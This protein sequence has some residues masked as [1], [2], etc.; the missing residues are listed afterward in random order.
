MP[1][2]VL[3]RRR[4]TVD[5]PNGRRSLRES[6]RVAVGVSAPQQGTQQIVVRTYSY[7][8]VV[9]RPPYVELL[10]RLYIDS[11][12]YLI[13]HPDL[14]TFSILSRFTPYSLHGH[15]S[16]EGSVDKRELHSQASPGKGGTARFFRTLSEV[17]GK[18]TQCS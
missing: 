9:R 14:V 10:Y 13:G 4:S 15:G 6:V 2:V 3:L 8:L 7:R 17:N 5:A 18:H 12:F 11:N 16:A 1:L